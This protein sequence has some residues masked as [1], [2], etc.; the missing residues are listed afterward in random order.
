[1]N[2][3]TG[4]KRINKLSQFVLAIDLG[5][6]GP[7]V[8]LVDIKGNVVAPESA[9]T[10]ILYF[11]G[12]GSEQDAEDWWQ[13]II[14]T[15]RKVIKKSGVNPE[16][17][18][19]IGCDSQWSLAVPVDG[20][21]HPVMNAIHWYDKRGARYNR[22]IASGFP[23]VQ[24]YGLFKLLSW[25][26]HTGLAPTL[27]G[28]DSLAHVLYIK[29]E[30]PDIFE[31]TH[32]FM[33]PMD[34]ITSRLT[35]RINATQKTMAPFLVVDTR[36]GNT[37]TYSPGMLRLA[38]MTGDKFPPLLHN[39]D[40]AGTIREVYAKQLGLSPTTK[41][42]TGIHDSNASII[43]AGASEYFDPIIYI[44]TS[45]YMTCHVPFKKTDLSS[46]MATIPGPFPSTWYVFGEQGSGGNNVEF[47]LNNL[48]YPQD[49]FHT[50]KLPD[51]AYDRFN[52]M[53]SRSPAGSNGVMYFPW[54][55]GTLVPC[56]DPFVRAGFINL[57]M[58]TNR[59]D[60][61]RA[62]FE[63]LAF[64][65]RW[66]ME[67]L[68]KFIGKKPEGFRFAGGGAL[69]NLWSQIHAD[70]LEVPIHQMEDPEHATL[71][72]TGLLAFYQMGLLKQEEIS[73]RAAIKQ[74]FY[75][76]LSNRELYG[77]MY[78]EYRRFFKMSKKI[79]RNLNS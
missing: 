36:N 66:T 8:A 3:D 38:G 78:R 54:L 27:S 79:Y 74:T 45:L 11:P 76:D 20:Q 28:T 44:G 5:G 62:V 64:N 75:P 49:E 2:K 37:N 40:I 14:T 31:K 48:V 26:K 4:K 60:M 42:V 33:D 6:S 63:G 12:N 25:I 70:I 1:M 69:S 73:T 41:V 61:A 13:K 39:S 35:G 72:G 17:V 59:G 30:L 51:N 68:E 58:N 29:N 56:E 16:Q 67:G 57:T 77:K 53:A 24:G 55:S 47:L 50:Q 46:F 15:S 21:A 18:I 7:R 32:A 34:Y 23:M 71:R 19:G 22:K 10:E 9:H 52:T 43:G 65:S